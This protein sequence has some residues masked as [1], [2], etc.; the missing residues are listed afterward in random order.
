MGGDGAHELLTPRP[1]PSVVPWTHRPYSASP[2]SDGRRVVVPTPHSD[3]T[4]VTTAPLRP[5][6]PFDSLLQLDH[7]RHVPAEWVCSPV[8]APLEPVVLV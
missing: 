3:S 2:F 6:H 1:P 5:S 7:L 4:P 8:L